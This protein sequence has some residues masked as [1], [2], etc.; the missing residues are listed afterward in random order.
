MRAARAAVLLN[1]LLAALAGNALAQR[2]LAAGR[3]VDGTLSFDAHAT[4]G[5]FTGTTTAVS[6]EMTGGELSAVRGWVEAPVKTLDTGNRRRDRDL[7]KSMESDRY[8]AIRFELTGVVPG[9][10]RGD[11]VDVTLLG[12]FRIHGVARGDTIPATVVLSGER[13]RVRARTPLDLKDYRI[14]GLSKGLGMLR[15]QEEILV[16]LDL[17][18]AQVP[19]RDTAAR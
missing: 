1:L 9:A 18:F 3:V 15:V 7:N 16:R 5:D 19:A 12:T 11:T 13:V 17:T 4:V 2:A 6:G 14:G 10:A 8:P